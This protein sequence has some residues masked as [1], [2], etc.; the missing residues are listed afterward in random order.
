VQEHS[1]SLAVDVTLKYSITSFN[2]KFDQA[3]REDEYNCAFGCQDD[4]MVVLEGLVFAD[5]DD[6]QER[7]SLLKIGPAV[8][9]SDSSF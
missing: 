1:S 8:Q 5:S 7:H 9:D 6:P 4:M 3:S 2:S